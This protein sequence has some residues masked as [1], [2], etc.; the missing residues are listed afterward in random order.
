[1]FSK[2]IFHASGI[3][4]LVQVIDIE[5]EK[6]KNCHTCISLCPVKYCNDGSGDFVVINSDTCIGCGN[7]LMACTHGARKYL[8]DFNEFMEVLK[9]EEKIIAIVAPSI[10]ANFPGQYFNF[11]GWLKSIGIE[12]IFDVSFGAEL[13]VKSYLDI[14]ANKKPVAIIAQ[15]CPAIVT[16]IELYKPELLDYLAPA[17]SPMLHTIKMI[18]EYYPQYNQS[19]IAIISP[20]LAK[21]RELQETGL[22]DYNVGYL[23]IDKY[24]KN[25][26]I[27]LSDYPKT[28]FDNPSAERAVLFS[29]PGGLMRTAERWVPDIREKTRKI[30]GVAYIYQY[31]DKVYEAILEGKGPLLIDCLNCEHGC[32]GGTLTLNKDKSLEEIEYWVEK[33]NKEVRDFY[34]NKNQEK[35]DAKEIEEIINSFWKPGL[36]DRKYIN[37]VNNVKI[38]IPDNEQLQDIFYKMHK[39]SEEDIYNC[40]ACGYNKCEKMATA[41]FNGLNKPENCHFYLSKESEISHNELVQLND[42][43]EEK[44]KSRTQELREKNELIMDSINYATRIQSAILPWE[45][46]IKEELKDYFILFK[47]KDVL[48][49]DFYWFHNVNGTI[50]IAA[51][52][53]TGHGIPGSMLSMI[54]YML[55]NEIVKEK[56]IYDPA[57][58]LGNLH[59]MTQLVLHQ[60]GASGKSDEGMDICF[61][62]I[63]KDKSELVFAG[64]RRPLYL[65]RNGKLNT[66]KG[67][68]KSIGGWQ[69]HDKIE[70]T[71]HKMKLEKGDMIYLTTDGLLDQANENWKRFGS[72]KFKEILPKIASEFVENQKEILMYQLAQHQSNEKQ[73]DDITIIGLKL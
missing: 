71:N 11:N 2:E 18:K 1:M 34:G 48:S 36:Y 54:G 10:A 70:F 3:P 44:V 50:F 14:I 61:C 69:I 72:K 45:S 56:E 55:L 46:K 33:R 47:P 60:Q 43:L 58:I 5:K 38:K 42:T 29:S 16:F 39:Y 21:K 28:D 30:E 15:P 20:C 67:D 57:E 52:D 53:C 51:V 66:V 17:D 9:S 8:D 23:T 62:R 4:N 19:K 22:G 26:S 49:G 12:A 65:V 6:C 27:N 64:A 68:K 31:L 35:A 32:N 59:E 63:D 73:V 25:N 37:R 7:C 40:S 24:L 13:T 41:I